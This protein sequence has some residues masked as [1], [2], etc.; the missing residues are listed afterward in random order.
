MLCVLCV[1][2]INWATAQVV[3]DTSLNQPIPEV[4]LEQADSI[5][6]VADTTTTVVPDVPRQ[7]IPFQPIPKKAGLYSAI[8]PG[9]GQVYNRQYW[10]VPIVYAGLGVAGYFFFDN[11]KQYQRYRRAYILR[12]Y[13]PPVVEEEQYSTEDLRS[14][15]NGYRQYVDITVLLGAVGYAAQILDAVAAAHLKNFDMSPDITMRMQPV[16]YPQGG[17]G[18]GL[19][20]NFK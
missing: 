9:A 3:P 6:A 12:L 18:V 19:V 2:S 5:R 8:L 10:K 11:L 15:Q 17:I 1:S 16:F 14:L 4:V 20:F 13:T 7:R